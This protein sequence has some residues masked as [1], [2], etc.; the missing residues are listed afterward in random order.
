V[1]VTCTEKGVRVSGVTQV[2]VPGSLNWEDDGD[3]P[4]PSLHR[5]RPAQDPACHRHRA[6]SHP[7]WPRGTE[8]EEG[9]W[10]PEGAWRW[11]RESGW[12]GW[13]SVR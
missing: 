6:R 11:E 9:S 1:R 12:G 10:V 8:R 4:S 7:T 5:T 3:A 13:C 2:D